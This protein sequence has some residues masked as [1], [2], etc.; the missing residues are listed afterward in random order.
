MDTA[1]QSDFL[2]VAEYL[3]SEERSEIRHEYL[4][5]MVYAMAGSSDAH[6]TIALNFAVALRGHLRGGRCRVFMAD[7]KTRL[8]IGNR[9]IFY[10]PDVMVTCD[11][12]DTDRYFKQYPRIILEVL[13]ESTEGTDRREKFWNYTQSDSLEEYILADQDQIEVTVFRRA[14]EWRPEIL[15]LSDQELQLTSIDLKLPLGS[16]Y[17]A[18]G[19]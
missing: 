4:G 18:V 13:S 19:V 17:E 11:A 1:T 14:N 5:G 12:R 2:T 3:A 10:Y 9:D 7:V 8:K 6:N 16:L 15:R